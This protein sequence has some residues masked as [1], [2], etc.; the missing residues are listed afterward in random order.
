[1]DRVLRGSA[2]TIQATFYADEAPVDSSVAVTIGIVNDLGDEIV[3]PGTA[4]VAGAALDGTYEYVLTPTDTARVDILTASWT[5]TI[6][7]NAMILETRVEVVGGFYFT[8]ADARGSDSALAS[9]S[10][11]TAAQIREARDEVEDECESICGVAFVP[12][13]RRLTR[14]GN[15][16]DS[17]V[18]PDPMVRQIFSLTVDGTAY[19]QD[20]LDDLI[21]DTG[22]ITN[23]NSVFGGQTIDIAYEHG[24]SQPPSD[25]R[26]AA[27]TRIKHQLFASH[28]AIPDRAI[29]FQSADG[30]TYSLATA[31]RGASLTGIPDVDAVYARHRYVAIA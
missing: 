1:M 29:S 24:H 10:K 14:A 13:Y 2:S 3:A 9:T 26:R 16:S 20:E 15:R 23:K 19:T 7:G 12:R 6:G 8:L 30:G 22:V 4:T 28:S 27:L 18:V 21:I 5:A 17:I 31:G 11:Y 25:I